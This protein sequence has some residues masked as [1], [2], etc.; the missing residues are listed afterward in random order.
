MR[1]V[2]IRRESQMVIVRKNPPGRVKIQGCYQRKKA[3]TEETVF[4]RE[5][6]ETS[7]AKGKW[8][9]SGVI[10]RPQGIN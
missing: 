3:K 10:I 4:R 2:N 8:R 5:V 1:M 7:K 6:R 9:D